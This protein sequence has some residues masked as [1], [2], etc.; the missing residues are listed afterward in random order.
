[1]SRTPVRSSLL[2]A[3][4]VT[5]RSVDALRAAFHGDVLVDGD[6]TYD[7]VRRVWNQMVDRRPAV[8]ARTTGVA[9]VRT[10]LA[11]A[12]AEGLDVTVRCGG[13]SIVGHGVA[14][15]ALLLDLAPMRG[16][17]VDPDRRQVLG[18]GWGPAARPRPRDAPVRSRRPGRRRR[19]HRR[20][21][22]LARRR[23]RLRHPALR[24]DVRQ[25]ARGRARDGRRRARPGRRGARARAAVGPPG[26]RRQLRRRHRPHL[27]AAPG[28]ADLVRRPPLPARRGSGP[29]A[30]DARPA[31]RR[32]GRG[33][34]LGGGGVRAGRGLGAG[35]VAGPAR[36]DGV[37][38]V[39]RPGR[40]GP[41]AVRTARRGRPAGGVGRGGDDV[42]RAAGVQRRGAGH[43]RPPVLEGRAGQ[44][45]SRTRRSR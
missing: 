21:W 42:R 25:P 28:R 34:R 10:A 17:R 35:G 15:E 8:V 19:R 36:G 38:G 13:H 39:P 27:P 41:P 16:V 37:V 18:P 14:D 24:A 30:G 2:G 5:E 1:M 9:D 6:E 45:T 43:G 4:T 31:A 40:R 23:L 22:P 11:Y 26:W 32:T 12:R 7:D 20:R 3:R 29:A 33:H 44:P